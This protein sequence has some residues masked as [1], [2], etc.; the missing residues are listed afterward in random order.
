[1]LD[2]LDVVEKLRAG[3]HAN[4]VCAATLARIL[5]VRAVEPNAFPST[6]A[7]VGPVLDALADRANVPTTALIAALAAT[8]P[9]RLTV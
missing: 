1:M 2:L 5:A 7:D 8:K 9:R 6:A 3:R 4:A